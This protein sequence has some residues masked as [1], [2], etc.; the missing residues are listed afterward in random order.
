MAPDVYG[1][2]LADRLRP[3]PGL[4]ATP[5]DPYDSMPAI[6]PSLS[7]K[8]L[9]EGWSLHQRLQAAQGVEGGN[10]PASA[11][12][13]LERWRERLAAD[14]NNSFDKRLEWDGLTLAGAAWALNPPAEA[15]PLAPAWWPLLE[16]L[17]QAAREAAAG[18]NQPALAGRG[19]KQPFVHVWRPAAA[20][21]LHCL[22]QRCA[23][24]E[25]RLQLGEGAW[26]DLGEALL[27][28]FCDIAD[29]ALWELFNQ[30]RTPGQVLLA[31]LGANGDGSGEPLHAAYDSFVAELL[32]SGYGL[33]LDQF[34]VLGRLLAVVAALW[35]EGS[36]EMLR[37]LAAS[38]AELHQQFAIDAVAPLVGI[39]LGLSDPHC[40]GRAVAILNFG[41]GDSTGRVVYKPKDMQVDLAYQ[42]LLQQINAASSLPPQAF[43]TAVKSDPSLQQRLKGAAEPAV[44]VMEIAKQA[45]FGF[46]K[47]DLEARAQQTPELRDAEL[48]AVAGGYLA[49]GW[50]AAAISRLEIGTCTKDKTCR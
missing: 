28:R 50:R 8:I 20:W 46:S 21:A 24:L 1:Q 29:Q 2:L 41:Q 38:R 3:P 13:S 31:H 16:A 4:W 36:E 19:S 18:A 39:Q 23:D 5:S 22:R 9:R 44:V 7:K 30:R 15:T 47:A 45:G 49:A 43:V 34:P 35:L 25:P 11:A 17:C 42:Q 10:Q 14:N 48:E 33:L 37:R 6:A 26:L 27:E 40:G 32:F 12:G